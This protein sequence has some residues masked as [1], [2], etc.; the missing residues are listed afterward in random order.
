M[1][2][3]MDALRKVTASLYAARFEAVLFRASRFSAKSED[4]DG[5]STESGGRSVDRDSFLVL[6]WPLTAASSLRVG[7]DE[8]I[9]LAGH[10]K[11]YFCGVGKAFGEYFCQ[12]GLKCRRLAVGVRARLE[13]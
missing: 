11:K 2:C 13:D 4:D 12:G 5:R 7:V 1:V 10:R 3:Q 9:V 6:T 8:E